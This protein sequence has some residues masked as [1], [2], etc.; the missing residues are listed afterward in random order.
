[1]TGMTIDRSIERLIQGV[2]LLVTPAQAGVQ[3]DVS[4]LAPDSRF[5]GNDDDRVSAAASSGGKGGLD[6]LVKMLQRRLVAAEGDGVLR[7]G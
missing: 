6:A 7:A 2:R 1:L 4:S 3:G 5:R